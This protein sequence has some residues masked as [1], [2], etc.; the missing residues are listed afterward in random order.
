VN[1]AVSDLNS[2]PSRSGADGLVDR[3][4]AAGILGISPRTLDRWHVLRIGPAR[5]VMRTWV[6]YR[7]ADLDA[8]VE[9]CRA[10]GYTDVGETR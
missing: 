7:R 4:T 8:W 6:R 9:A 5:L 3:Q 2:R 10:A 1:S